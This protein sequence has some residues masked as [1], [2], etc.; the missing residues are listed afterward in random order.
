MNE[1]WGQPGKTM[2][3]PDELDTKFKGHQCGVHEYII[4]GFSHQTNTEKTR[5][6]LLMIII[7]DHYYPELKHKSITISRS[8]D[9][10]FAPY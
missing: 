4:P 7:H 3:D 1:T 2:K 8:N 9:S 6:T 10:Y 5:P